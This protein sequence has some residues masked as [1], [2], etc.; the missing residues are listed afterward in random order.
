MKGWRSSL[1]IY[2][3]VSVVAYL[4][5]TIFGVSAL[6]ALLLLIVVGVQVMTGGYWW[7]LLQSHRSITAIELLGMGLAIGTASSML[8]GVLFFPLHLGVWAWV[9]PSIAAAILWVIR[10]ARG[11]RTKPDARITAPALTA[12]I[13]GGVLGVAS[14]VVNVASYP[15]LWTGIWD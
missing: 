10:L 14:F 13:I 9:V 4:L 3:G 7:R 15:L 1:A 2:G 11:Q 12:L 5:L 8:S 6:S